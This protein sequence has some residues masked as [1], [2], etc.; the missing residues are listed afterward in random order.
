MMSGFAYTLGF[1]QN[2]S[3]ETLIELALGSSPQKI[4]GHLFIIR[5]APDGLECLHRRALSPR[6][7]RALLRPGGDFLGGLLH[8][9]LCE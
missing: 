2:P 3:L 4:L 7:G 1:S 5:K 8:R 6:Y 9:H